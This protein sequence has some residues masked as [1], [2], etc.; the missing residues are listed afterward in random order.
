MS[1]VLIE[2]GPNAVDRLTLIP[3][4]HRKP[5]TATLLLVPM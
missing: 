4:Y 5:K 2:E 3:G 1:K